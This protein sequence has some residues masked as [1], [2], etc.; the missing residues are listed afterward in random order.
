MLNASFIPSYVA[1]AVALVTA[2]FLKVRLR[3]R[4]CVHVLRIILANI[5]GCVET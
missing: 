1:A 4:L 2:V 3:P 5:S